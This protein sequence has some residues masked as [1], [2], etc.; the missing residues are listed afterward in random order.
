MTQR[1]FILTSALN[2]RFSKFDTA[3]R[4]EQTLN[5]IKS[6]RERV[7]DAKIALM[8][9]SGIPL[10]EDQIEIF[11]NN[12]EWFLN[13]STDPTIQHIYNS[14]ENW[15]I[16]KNLCELASFN[17]TLRILDEAGVFQGIDRFYK[18]SGRYLLNDDFDTDVHDQVPD[19][20]ILTIKYS[21]QFTDMEIPYQY[22]SRLWSWPVC[23][24]EDI[25]NFYTSAINEFTKRLENGRYVDIE[26]LMYY[27]LPPEHIHEVRAIG[28]EGL[29]GPN[30]AQVS[31]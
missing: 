23:H 29:L 14:T 13:M 22:M 31:N 1:L 12:C 25:K 28:V 3:E 30:G 2:T 17:S 8:D 19:K 9:C 16:V 27:F 11:K 4:L 18:L 26:H 5:T 21:T 10:S 20:I 6:V 24:L 15:D 7:P